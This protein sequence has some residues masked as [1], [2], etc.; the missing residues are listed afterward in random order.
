MKSR[1][2]KNKSSMMSQTG[3]PPR[4]L[5]SSAAPGC[6]EARGVVMSAILTYFGQIVTQRLA[7]AIASCPRGVPGRSLR[8]PHKRALIG[9]AGTYRDFARDAKAFRMLKNPRRTV[10]EPGPE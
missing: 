10:A 5:R 4:A 3:S 6:S 2:A 8:R 1:Y 7:A 9:A